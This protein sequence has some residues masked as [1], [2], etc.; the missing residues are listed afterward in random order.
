[1]RPKT[2]CCDSTLLRSRQKHGALLPPAGCCCCLQPFHNLLIVSSAQIEQGPL[3]ISRCVVLRG[4][5]HTEVRVTEGQS[6]MTELRKPSWF[7]NLD[8][9]IKRF[10]ISQTE[11]LSDVQHVY[12]SAGNH[13][14][15]KGVV[16]CSKTLEITEGVFKDIEET[17]L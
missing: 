12:L 7:T 5:H 11:T 17:L 6:G 10:L 2:L 14:A 15:D 9:V 4:F 8:H 3:V 1:M 16:S 13:D